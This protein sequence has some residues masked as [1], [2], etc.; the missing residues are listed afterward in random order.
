[1]RELD[2]VLNTLVTFLMF[3]SAFLAAKRGS[4]GIMEDSWGTNRSDTSSIQKSQG[5][6]FSGFNVRDLPAVRSMLFSNMKH[7]T[8]CLHKV[9]GGVFPLDRGIVNLT[10]LF[11]SLLKALLLYSCLRSPW[12]RNCVIVLIFLFC[13]A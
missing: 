9:S 12:F 10:F 11:E 1:M 3:I 6:I 2:S 13:N 8:D 5:A 4:L 7:M